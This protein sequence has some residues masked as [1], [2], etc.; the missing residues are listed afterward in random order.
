MDES[1]KGAFT[2]ENMRQRADV[3]RASLMGKE[4]LQDGALL[5]LENDFQGHVHEGGTAVVQFPFKD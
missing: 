5:G 4:M 3:Y 1:R 2:A